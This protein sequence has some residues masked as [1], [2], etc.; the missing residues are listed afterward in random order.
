MTNT[1]IKT[2]L[3]SV[4]AL[5]VGLFVGASS[6]IFVFTPK[7]DSLFFN[8]D[9]S[10]H[11]LDSLSLT[12]DLSV[13]FLEL[14]NEYAGDSIYIKANDKDILIDAGSRQNSATTISNY[15]NKYC[16]D[17]TLEYVIATHAHQDHI[18]AF[19]STSTRKGIFENYE[20]KNI[21]DFGDA[22]KYER[23]G[24]NKTQVYKDY[25]KYRDEEIIKNKAKYAKVSDYNNPTFLDGIDGANTQNKSIDL[26]KGITL[27]ILYNNFYID[28]TTN[29][30]NYSVCVL[31][32]SGNKKVLLTG[33]LEAEGEKNLADNNKD[34]IANS[35]LFKAAHHG[36]YTGSTDALLKVV[37]P[38][39][40][41]FTCVAGSSEYTN[42]NDNMFPSQKAISSI[43]KYTD[44]CY[45]TS[46]YT[47]TSQKFTSMNGNIVF[48]VNGNEAKIECTNNNTILK[49]TDWFK[50]NRTWQMAS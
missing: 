34:D 43:A 30:N 39:Y 2:I 13:H 22:T 37:K 9:L 29:E 45:V 24:A 18:A 44:K 4:V 31:L 10:V 5:I 50:E 3:F 16:T 38:E 48:I 32:T 11:F 27:K 1:K 15:V 46:L 33:D 7:S 26:G 36:S 19:P 8:G 35:T 17:G 25:V 20:V 6:Y 47:E 23:N 12:G 14:G 49:D 40:V 42:V 41:A 28:S 21:I